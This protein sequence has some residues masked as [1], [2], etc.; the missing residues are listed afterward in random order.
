VTIRAKL[1]VAMLLTVLG[2]VITIGVALHGM[3][4]LGQALPAR[5]RAG[6]LGRLEPRTRPVAVDSEAA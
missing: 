6:R 3:N 1:Y 5:W 4:R 2:P